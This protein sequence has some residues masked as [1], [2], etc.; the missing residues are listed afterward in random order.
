[1]PGNVLTRAIGR[2]CSEHA[3]D[4]KIILAPS[5]RIGTQWLDAVARGGQPVFNARAETLTG[6]A[7]SI[8]AP[9]LEKKGLSTLRGLSLE[10][11]VDGIVSELMA[12]ATLGSPGLTYLAGLAPSPGLTRTVARMLSELREA[13]VAASSVEPRSFEVERKGVEVRTMMER[14][15]ELLASGGHA[16]EAAIQR[17][18]IER[19]KAEPEAIGDVTV[20][21]PSDAER[22]LRGLEKALWEAVPESNRAVLPADEPCMAPP[23]EQ[24]ALSDAMLLRWSS[25]PAEAPAP[26]GDGSARITSAIGEVN[27]V[28][29]VFRD[30]A[31]KQIPLDQVEVVHTDAA[32][33]VGHFYELA[34]RMMEEGAD[35]LPVTFYEG[36]PARYSRPGRALAAWLAWARDG[37]PQQQMA[38][39]IQEGLLNVPVEGDTELSAARLAAILRTVPIGAGRE[40]YASQL[41]WAADNLRRRL[42]E[43]AVSEEGLEEDMHGISD[44]ERASLESRLQGIDVLRGLIAGLLSETPV[45]TDDDART[46]ACAAFFIEKHGRA[47]SMLDTYSRQALLERV[48][49]L[50]RC[51][52]DAGPLAG[53]DAEAWLEDLPSSVKVLGQGPSPG[54]LYVSNIEHGGH[55]GRPHTYV[56]GLDDT[57]FP[58]AGLQDPL[59]L[60]GERAAISDD[61]MTA[62]A[63][64][65]RRVEGFARLAARLRGE[66]TLSYCARDL[67]DDREMF[68]SRILV[69]AGRVLTGEPIAVLKLHV[70]PA[71]FA[72]TGEARCIDMGEWWLWRMC[73]GEPVARPTEVIGRNFSNLARGFVALAARESDLFTEYDG[74]VP[75]AG[76]A[77]DCA[78]PGGPM[79]SPSRLEV[80]ARNPMEYFFQYVLKIKPP[81]EYEVDTTQWLDVLEQGSLLHAV[82]CDFMRALGEQGMMPPDFR[83]DRPALIAILDRHVE[84]MK[85]IKP[86]PPNPDVFMS[87]YRFLKATA[88]TFLDMEEGYCRDHTPVACELAIGVVPEGTGTELDIDEP[89]DLPLLDGRTVRVRCKLDRV[90]RVGDGHDYVVRDYKTGSSTRFRDNGPFHGGRFMQAALYPV[91]GEIALKRRYGGDVKV[92]WFEY[93]FPSPRQRTSEGWPVEQLAEGLVLVAGLCD[94]TS[95]GCFAF[96]TTEDDLRYS[97]YRAAFGDVGSALDAIARKLANP[98]NTVLA[99]YR[100]LR[101]A[102]LPED[103]SEVEGGRR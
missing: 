32:T 22:D 98:A 18:A 29:E 77:S 100:K 27:E 81:D 6:L 39:M 63:R 69:S 88:D 90:D 61:L 80:L 12:G 10:V 7:L 56:V 85:V 89:V 99:P 15:E 65:D 70:P 24:D 96:A 20:L 43:A 31:E 84:A 48:T 94:L 21:I 28:R 44:D 14:Y 3:L 34:V 71:S 41:D 13:G 95:S 53:F 74:W 60:D 30:C 55:S 62:S 67:G 23:D 76:P 52:T 42:S 92:V 58:G 19:L 66:V 36:I 72:P 8:A 86:P 40:R 103:P 68:P 9:L 51:L 38:R 64:I 101:E 45:E 83:R 102:E 49:E 33:Y 54:K 37:F 25:A 87:G 57:R 2:Y 79:V 93:M 97:D 75:D 5:R 78:S 47:V 26:A 4:E 59:L 73:T 11:A 35:E 46:V 1:L 17:S 82:F 91:L 16:D 50:E